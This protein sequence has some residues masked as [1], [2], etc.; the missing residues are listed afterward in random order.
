MQPVNKEKV[1][2]KGIGDRGAQ[3]VEKGAAQS[4]WFSIAQAHAD[5]AARIGFVVSM[6]FL[7]ATA[8]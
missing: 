6:M 7:A 4:S 1:R 5:Y 3:P 2:S 8:F